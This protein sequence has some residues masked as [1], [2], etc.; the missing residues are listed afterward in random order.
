MLSRPSYTPDAGYSGSAFTIGIGKDYKQLKFHAFASVDFLQGTAFEESPLV[1]RK[2]SWMGGFSITWV[3]LKSEK[4]VE[5][6]S[7]Y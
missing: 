1:K 4:T 6:E 3:F 5:D 7:P 2:M